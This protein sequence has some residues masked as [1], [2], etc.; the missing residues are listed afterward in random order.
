[1]NLIADGLHP[2]GDELRI[3]HDGTYLIADKMILIVDGI[4]FIDDE[5][6]METLRF[7]LSPIGCILSPQR[8]TQSAQ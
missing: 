5:V 4:N 1:M 6:S 3:S 2:I 7:V 8:R